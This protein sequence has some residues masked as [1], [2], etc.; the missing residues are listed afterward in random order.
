MFGTLFIKECKQ[1]L[2]SLAYYLYL[3]ILIFFMATQMGDNKIIEKPE[4]GQEN[5]GTKKSDDRQAIME[6][7]LANLVR[8]IE[9]ESFATYPTA[10]YKE[11]IPSQKEIEKLK[12]I[13]E[14]CTGKNWDEIVNERIKHYSQYDLT[15]SE[16]AM[17]ADV[18]YR[19][20]PAAGASYEEFVKEMKKVCDIIGRGSDFEKSK[21]EQGVSVEKTYEDALEEYQAIC[22]EDRLTGAYMRLFCDYAGIML[23]LL[24]VFLGVTRCMRDKRSKAEEVIYARSGSSVAIMLGRYLANVV[25]IFVPVVLVAFI[26]Q[27]SYL[28][29]AK[30][31]GITPDYIAFLAYSVIW[32]LPVILVVLSM[33]F[34]LTELTNGIAAVIIQVFWAFADL[35]SGGSLIG[36]FGRH[37][38]V[39]WNTFGDT[40]NYLAQR[41]ELYMNRGIYTLA[42]IVFIVLTILLYERKRKGGAG[43]NGKLLKDRC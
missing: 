34:L 11:V 31:I 17:M 9:Q 1:V 41:R 37:L 10:F 38:I 30:T 18:T 8:Q 6:V 20:E 22:D 13:V 15:D 3:I 24:P 25:M 43:L 21:F 4:P 7:T 27:S 29:Q 5:Y 14:E 19:L 39:R 16:E 35:M 12:E 26:M 40:V 32:L 23:S 28:Y 42:A 36:G 33:S 2:R